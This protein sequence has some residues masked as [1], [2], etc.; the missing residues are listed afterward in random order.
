MEL[1]RE[2]SSLDHQPRVRMP[3]DGENLL[4]LGLGLLCGGGAGAVAADQVAVATAYT[5]R[6]T[7]TQLV[8]QERKTKMAD[9][10]NLVKIAD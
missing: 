6:P 4:R 1:Y 2:F 10:D 5:T 3:E 8:I 9:T 7:V